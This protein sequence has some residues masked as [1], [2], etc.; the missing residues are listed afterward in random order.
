M[1]L[2]FGLV[3][4]RRALARFTTITSDICLEL[5]QWGWIY[6]VKKM[7]ITK[8]HDKEMTWD[9]PMQIKRTLSFLLK[10]L[11]VFVSKYIEE[12]CDF[13]R[14]SVGKRVWLCMHPRNLVLTKIN[15]YARPCVHPCMESKAYTI[16][17][18]VIPGNKHPCHGQL[19]A[20]K[21]GICWSLWH[22]TL[23]RALVD[24]TLRW[25]FF[26]V[27]LWPVFGFQLIADS[28]PYFKGGIQ[29]AFCLW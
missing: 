29:F 17:Y 28:G 19:T 9:C 11:I 6:R 7:T 20:F 13:K 22:C 27:I 25:L 15:A 4:P 23:S 1:R 2:R 16:W 3:F 18:L 14:S 8:K 24:A 21:K 26:K 5:R 10:E 12:H